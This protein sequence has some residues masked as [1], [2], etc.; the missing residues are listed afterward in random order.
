MSKLNYN[1]ARIS[2]VKYGSRITDTNASKNKS[3][4]NNILKTND[5][6]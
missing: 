4:G 6:A 2:K 1:T 5:S 3:Y